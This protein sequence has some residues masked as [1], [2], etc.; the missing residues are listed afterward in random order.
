MARYLIFARDR[1]EEPLELHG[2]LE[3]DGDDAAAQAAPGELGDGDWI[4][5]QLVPDA[6]IR[7]VV[8]PAGDANPEE[9]Q[10]A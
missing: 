5:I 4:E 1:Y 8:Q 7:W 3:A 10:H 2:T 6:A 9:V